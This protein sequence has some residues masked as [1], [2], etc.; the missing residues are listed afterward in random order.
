MVR[1]VVNSA[2]AVWTVIPDNARGQ[3]LVAYT[4]SLQDVY[5]MGVPFAALGLA[6]ALIIK[7]DRMQTK[8]EEDSA[9]ASAREKEALAKAALS[10]PATGAAP[11]D[12]ATVEKAAIRD[13]QADENEEEE[14]F[15]VAGVAGV[16]PAVVDGGPDARVV[17]DT[18]QGKS[19]V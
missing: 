13:A 5:I 8:A 17:L 3:V 19:P 6:G 4:R 9:I 7:N 14:A 1:A 12:T 16:P 10:A 11:A 18:Q 2:E 15:A